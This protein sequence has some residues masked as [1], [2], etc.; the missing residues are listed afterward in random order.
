MRIVT[1]N[2]LD[3][4]EGR[5]DPIAE[6]I[7]AQK[8]DIVAITEAD[9]LAVLERLALRLKM[10]YVQAAGEGHA[11]ALLSRWSIRESINHAALLADFRGSCLEALLESTGGK[12][13]IAVVDSPD[14]FAKALANAQLITG[15]FDT[16]KAATAGYTAACPKLAG[17]T[18]T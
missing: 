9:N 2:I 12:W 6:V 5:A 16:S 13:R 4:G 18:Y 14:D 7:L 10:D 8:P 11:C 1:Y 3:G 15:T 17:G